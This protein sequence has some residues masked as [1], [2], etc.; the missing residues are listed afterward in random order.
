MLQRKKS[1]RWFFRWGAGIRAL[2]LLIIR[3]D[4]MARPARFELT[5]TAFGG[6]YSIQLSYGRMV[7]SVTD[8]VSRL[9]CL[10]ALWP[11]FHAICVS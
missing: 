8:F 4:E 11:Y 1:Q 3:C 2:N 7:R 10:F 9:S 6:R 5:T